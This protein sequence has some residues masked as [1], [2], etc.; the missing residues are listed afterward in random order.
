[1]W[2]T[3]DFCCQYLEREVNEH[4]YLYLQELAQLYSLER[5][6]SFIDHFVLARF[7]T[8][9][10]TPDFLQNVP[11]HKLCSYLSSGQVKFSFSV[12]QCQCGLIKKPSLVLHQVQHHSEQALLQACLQWLSQSPERTLH[13]KQLLSLIRFP[14]MPV[15]DLVSLVLPAIRGGLPEGAGCEELVEEALRYHARL[16][17]QPLLQ[18]GR[19][20]LRGGVE[21]L[22]L[23]GGE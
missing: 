7:S 21:Q 20:V 18:T 10:F 17:A 22:L 9:S 11:L 4:N 14:L 6:D 19:S 23:I 5:L 16:S 8:L 12:T 13:A 2:R 1:L 3:V 15:G